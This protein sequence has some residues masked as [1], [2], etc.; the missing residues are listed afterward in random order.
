MQ[1]I[2]SDYANGN[3]N[4]MA[5]GGDFFTD[6]GEPEEPT[7]RGRQ[8]VT[9]RINICKMFLIIVAQTDIKEAKASAARERNAKWKWISKW[10]KRWRNICVFNLSDRVYSTLIA[11]LNT[12][13]P[14]IR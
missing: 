4:A 10:Y 9:R 7:T 3:A 8:R 5:M 2:E 1:G 12:P 6:W 13:H 11:G 14:S